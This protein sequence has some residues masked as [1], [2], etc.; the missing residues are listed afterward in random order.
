MKE[1]HSH[2]C[3]SIWSSMSG[4]AFCL[5]L[6]M[7]CLQFS[8]T[9]TLISSLPAMSDCCSSVQL[10]CDHGALVN[11]RDLDGRTPLALATQMCRPAI[12]Q[13]LVEKGAEIN[14]RDKQ[15]K[16]IIGIVAASCHNPGILF[17]SWWSGFR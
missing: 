7:T 12:C 10:L 6:K 8:F 17:F 5:L 13:L 16:K 14:A 3:S 15:N 9:I 1:Q 2:F 4:S 11:A